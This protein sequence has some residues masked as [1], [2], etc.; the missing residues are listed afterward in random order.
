MSGLNKNVILKMRSLLTLLAP[1][2]LATPVVAQTSIHTNNQTKNYCQECL[3]AQ[4]PS[5][6]PQDITPPPQPTPQPTPTTPQL[7]PPEELLT[8]PSVT[9][10]P[11]EVPESSIPG[12]LT[13]K[14]FEFTGNTAISSQELA[15]VTAPYTNR[16]ISFAELLQARSTVT[17]LYIDKGYVTSG[18]LIPLQTLTEGV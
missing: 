10:Q 11:G 14:R 8:P 7:P 3:L 17:Q 6:P 12:T 1:I 5:I 13:V 2:W 18:A 4:F 15:T 9:P 16:P